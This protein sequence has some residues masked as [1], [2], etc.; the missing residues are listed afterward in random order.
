VHVEVIPTQD[1]SWRAALWVSD[2]VWSAWAE[3]GKAHIAVS[4]GSSPA[5]MFGVLAGLRLPWEALHVWQ[6][7]ERVA[8]D[9]HPDRN[10]NQ[11]RPLRES[12]ATVHEMDVVD[13]DLERAAVAYAG[14]LHVACGGILD[15]VHLG[16]GADGHTASWTPGDSVIAIGDRDVAVSQE[17]HGRVR[18]TLTRPAV[19]RARA[20]C[21]LVAGGT[22]A[23][24]LS[25]LLTGDPSVPATGVVT[26]H[27]RCFVDP[28]A[29]GR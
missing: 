10:A 22:K 28:A 23:R 3:R 26:D 21:F 9:G 24:A 27:A 14:D 16:L 6:V 5:A 18:L 17:Y 4:G 8:P 7:D 2:R 20:I 1:V 15:V 19:N 13:A 25:G 29:A 12:G 11:L